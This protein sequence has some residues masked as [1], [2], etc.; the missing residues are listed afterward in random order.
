MNEITKR[1]IVVMAGV[2]L[3]LLVCVGFLRDTGLIPVLLVVLIGLMA[4]AL[5]VIWV[6]RKAYQASIEKRQTTDLFKRNFDSISKVSIIGTD[7]DGLI[8][9]FNDG[10]VRMLGYSADEMIGKQTPL[11]LHYPPEVEERSRK[12]SEELGEAVNGFKTFVQKL[13]LDDGDSSDE[14]WTYVRKDGTHIRVNLSISSIVD[15]AGSVVGYFGVAMDLTD[16]IVAEE[17]LWD[18]RWMLRNVLD[19]IPVRVFWKDRESIYLGGNQHFANDAGLIHIEEIIGKDD[20]GLPWIEQAEDYRKDDAY[21]MENDI[22]KI[23]Y[24]ERQTRENGKIG[25]L[26]T[27]KIP[28]RDGDGEI[29]GVL[30]TYEDITKRKEAEEAL[31][32]AKIEAEDAN[33]A[34]DEFLAVVSHEIRTPLNPILGFANLMKRTITSKPEAEYLDIIYN[35]ANRQLNMIDDILDFMKLDRGKVNTS[36]EPSNIVELCTSALQDAEPIAKGLRLEFVNGEQGHAIPLHTNVEIDE[37]MFR[38]ILDN[39]LSNACK[40]TPNG[41]VRLSVSM[42]EYDEGIFVFSV[43]DTGIGIDGASQE[44]L[45]DVFSQV[46]SS[47]NRYYDGL[48]LGLAICKKLVDFL[49]GE[50]VLHSEVGKGSNFIVRLPLSIVSRRDGATT[51]ELPISE[52]VG[53]SEPYEVL[54]ADDKPDNLSIARAMVESYG[55]RVVAVSNGKEAVQMCGEREFDAIL[56]DLAMPV[57]NGLEASKAIKSTDNKNRLTPIIAVTADVSRNVR[58]SC[59]N[60]GIDG[61]VSKPIDSMKLF[62]AIQGTRM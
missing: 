2:G 22:S 59:L 61:Y 15:D 26:N 48:G 23:N 13:V 35:S 30:G 14:E 28:L 49:N 62:Q 33:K 58:D 1:L 60:A 6:V 55:G 31:I 24:E 46:D 3:P 51:F 57:L 10:A 11:A 42:D 21:V 54:I 19:A 52:T 43:Q 45:F 40:F 25:W 56:M 38:R 9:I 29:I 39:L 37:V 50:I 8:T 44:Q 36:F 20:Q 4:M 32:A 53:F 7:V 12:L 27:S 18:S 16:R 47:Y 34:K 41:S 5:G 17:A